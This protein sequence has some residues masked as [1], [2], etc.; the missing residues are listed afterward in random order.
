M[1]NNP[2]VEEGIIDCQY[3]GSGEYL[4]NE[5][6]NQNSYCGQCGTRIDWPETKL[7]DWNV[8]TINLPKPCSIVMAKYGERETRVWYSMQGNWMP[9]GVLD[10]LKV[11]DA[12]RYLKENEREESDS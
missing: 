8:P 7:D 3:C 9:D 1:I 2:F 6:G 11:P 5:D 4:Y 12:W 10:Y